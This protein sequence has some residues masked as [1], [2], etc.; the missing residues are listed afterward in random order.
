M[1][2][3]LEDMYVCCIRDYVSVCVSMSR[4][5]GDAVGTRG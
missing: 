3:E 4:G 2:F 1:V 5:W